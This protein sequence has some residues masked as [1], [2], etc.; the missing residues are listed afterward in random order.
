[1]NNYIIE[2]RAPTRES[3][4]TTKRTPT[5]QPMKGWHSHQP[6]FSCKDIRDSGASRGDG[7]YWIDPENGGNALQVYCDMTTDGGKTSNVV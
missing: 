3:A 7:E 5:T 6:A 1:M 4:T 2:E